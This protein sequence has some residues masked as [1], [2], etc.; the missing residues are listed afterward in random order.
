MI[1]KK[2]FDLSVLQLKI[3]LEII[4]HV[5]LSHAFIIFTFKL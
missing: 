5:I 2:Y 3:I 1:L 4:I